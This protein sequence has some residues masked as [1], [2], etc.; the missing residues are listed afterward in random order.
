MPGALDARWR[1]RAGHFAAARRRRVAAPLFCCQPGSSRLPASA[2]S[3]RTRAR[4]S[5]GAMMGCVVLL[6]AA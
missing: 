6:P 5:D 4:H 3:L 1:S 2:R